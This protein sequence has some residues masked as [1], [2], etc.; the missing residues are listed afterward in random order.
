MPQQILWYSRSEEDS[1]PTFKRRLQRGIQIISHPQD[2]WLIARLLSW[3]LVLPLLK[4]V[5]PLKKLAP[6][7]WSLPS[8]SP[9]TEREQ[10]I[11]AVVRWIYIFIF[12]NE[13]SCLERSLLLYRFLSR[14][15]QDPRLVTGMRRTETGQWNGHAWIEVDGKPFE[16]TITHV[17]DFR[18]LIFFGPEGVM[19]QAVSDSTE[20]TQ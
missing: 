4:R 16:E 17:Q 12:S 10:K 14:N 3:S 9:D 5:V 20:I 2:A 6:F 8:G 13:K 11:A 7:M 15:N 18:A 19:E 1:K